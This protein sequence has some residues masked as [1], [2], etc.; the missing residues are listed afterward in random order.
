MGKTTRVVLAVCLCLMADGATAQMDKWTVQGADIAG[1]SVTLEQAKEGS[2]V[3]VGPQV[4]AKSGESMALSFK[5]K[6]EGLMRR[7]DGSGLTP[8]DITEIVVTVTWFNAAGKDVDERLLSLGFPPTKRV[9]TFSKN[10]ELEVADNLVPPELAESARVSFALTRTGAGPAGKA[11]VSDVRLA[12]GQTE[13]KGIDVPVSGPADAGPLSTRPEGFKFGPNLVQNAALEEGDAVPKGWSLLGDNSQGAALW[14]QGGAYSG[15]RCLQ[16]FDRAP[17]IQSWDNKSGLYVPGGKPDPGRANAREEVAARFAS[18]PVPA[19]PGAY[20]QATGMLWYLRKVSAESPIPI[21]PLRIQFQDADGKTLPYRFNGEDWMPSH[22]PVVLPGWRRVLTHPVPAPANAKTVRLVVALT[23]AM[24]FIG[25]PHPEIPVNEPEERGFVLVD[26]IALYRVPVDKL[27]SMTEE[28]SPIKTSPWVA[29]DATVKAGVMP[30]VPTSPAR[31]PNSLD[32]ETEAERPCGVIVANPGEPKKLWLR[33][34]NLGGDL[35]PLEIKHDILDCDGKA[36]ISGKTSIELKPFADARVDVP[37]PVDLPY[38]P[39]T[40][41]YAIVDSGHE[42]DSGEPRFAVIRPNSSTYEEKIRMDYPFGTWC[43]IFGGYV[44]NHDEV[45]L[46]LIGEFN[47]MAGVGKQGFC[48]GFGLAGL[49]TLPPDK[50]KTEVAKQ[51]ATARQ[52]GDALRRYEMQY[53]CPLTPGDEPVKPENYPALANVMREIVAAMKDQVKVWVYSDEYI[54]GSVTDLDTDRKSDGSKMMGWGRR[55]T[56]RQF[57]NEYFACYDGAK[58]ADPECLFGPESAADATGNVLRILFEKLDHKRRLDFFGIN[59]FGSVF[60]IWPP[61][62]VELRKAGMESLPLCGQNFI[63]FH[64]APATGPERFKQESEAVRRMISYYPE[65]LYGFP[66][67]F[68][69]PQWGWT[70]SNEPGSFSYQKRP[71]PQYVAYANMTDCLG[72]GKFVAKHELPGGLLFVRERAVR[73]GLVGV[74]W[75]TAAGAVAELDVGCETVELSDAWGNRRTLKAED[76]VV[77]VSLIPMPQY[78]LGAKT[79]KPAPSVRITLSNSSMSP[80]APEVTVAIVN[81]RKEPVSGRLELL[82]ESAIAVS[83]PSQAVDAI[84]AGATKSFTFQVTPVDPELDKP[85]AIRARLKAAS[86]T[87]EAVNALNFHF[88]V[89]TATPPAIDGDLTGWDDV[90]PFVANRDEQL[91]KY[92]NQKAWSGPEELSGRLWMRWDDKNLYLAAKVRDRNFNPAA[93]LGDL[94]ASDAIEMAFDLSG[95]L[96]KAAKVTQIALGQTRDG[97]ARVFR[98]NPNATELADAKIAIKR[99]GMVTIIEAAVP[100]KDLSPAFVP[101]PGATISAVFGFNDCDEGIRMM[102]WFNKVSGLDASSF[103]LIRLVEPPPPGAAARPLPKNLLENGALDFPA[104][105]QE[106]KVTVPDDREEKPTGRASLV[107]GHLRLETLIEQERQVG[108]TAWIVPVKPGEVYLFRARAKGLQPS[109]W[110]SNHNRE[111]VAMDL[112]MAWMTPIS[113]ATTVA[114]GRGVYL[115]GAQLPDHG[116][117]FAPVAVVFAIPPQ[118]AWL[119]VNFSKNWMSGIVDFDDVELYLLEGLT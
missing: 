65:A 101:K 66:Q 89:K 94:W 15:K 84:A 54:N 95:S 68:F 29:Y 62:L 22:D 12:S 50:M 37:C 113:P 107:D 115:N 44:G 30:F 110:L 11:T 8:S 111:K 2:R 90:C 31:R 74:L 7:I 52:V 64:S 114:Y 67:L 34:T 19:T 88:A 92:Q 61:Q 112:G 5:Y 46:R 18:D 39:Y 97:K 45:G 70:L 36:V 20:Y 85:L 73:P 32:V 40:L 17:F 1:T 43:W 83:T 13:L 81:E 75:S 16:I 26:N 3:A 86:R 4:T 109:I 93:T 72:A 98:Y 41:R 48:A 102:S 51:A 56:G 76:G 105:P 82:P 33:L 24:F 80:L 118:S 96:D 25:G 55:G 59:M 14:R 108:V 106:W 47:R 63:A 53:I 42:S 6:A 60:S 10:G 78:L 99:D 28:P 27:P 49:E 79:L 23:H 71:R 116:N 100:W 119:S 87:Y 21:N 38:G 91:F 35:R 117:D 69:L 9:W 58:Q 103:G 104:M 57:W 77:Q